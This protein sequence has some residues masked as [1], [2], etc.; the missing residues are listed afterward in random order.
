MLAVCIWFFGVGF[1][2]G[3]IA[4]SFLAL[5]DSW[6]ILHEIFDVVDIMYSQY[7]L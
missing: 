6:F 1:I 5:L 7:W 4:R 2:V 3:G